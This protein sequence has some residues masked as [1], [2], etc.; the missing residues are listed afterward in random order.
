M[1]PRVGTLRLGDKHRA[2]AKAARA[3]VSKRMK[4]VKDVDLIVLHLGRSSCEAMREARMSA[5]WKRPA[6][7]ETPVWLS[8]NQRVFDA[9]WST[10]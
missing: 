4:Q 1:T 9:F 5:K 8:P 2:K 6:G 10:K 7:Y 3:E